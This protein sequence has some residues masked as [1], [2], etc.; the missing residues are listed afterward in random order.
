MA[1]RESSGRAQAGV[2]LGL[3]R[4]VG[5]RFPSWGPH[6]QTLA[7]AIII[8]NLCIG[9]PLFRLAIINAGESRFLGGLKSAG[10][11]SPLPVRVD[12]RHELL[13]DRDSRLHPSQG[14]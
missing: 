3:A 5:V 12:S 4:M 7:V 2:A 14:L 13:V 6:F 10:H 8:L 11:E 9:P 1:R